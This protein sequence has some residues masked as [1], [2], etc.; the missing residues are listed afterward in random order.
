MKY[1]KLFSPG[2]IGSLEVK[3]RIV[4]PA[5]GVSFATSTGEAGDDIIAY[6]EERAKNGCGLII[7]EITRI[8][9][10]RGVGTSNQLALTDAKHVPQ[11][12]RLVMAVHKHGAKLFPQ[13]HHPGRQTSSR[14]MEGRA[15]VAPSPIPCGICK[16]MPDELTTQQCEEVRNAFIKGAVLA[17]TAGCDGVEVHAAHGYLIDQFLSPHTNQRTDKYGGS[18]TNRMRILVEIITSIKHMCGPNFPVCVRISADEY[19]EGGNTL[20]ETVKIA[21]L[22]ESHGVDAI[23]VSCGT[24]ESSITIIEP[25]S[26][27]QGW[28]RHLAETIRKHI[29]IPVIAVNAIKEPAVAEKLLEEG[30]CDF[31]GVGRGHLADAAWARKA[32]AGDDIAIRKCLGCMYCFSELNTGRKCKCAINPVL[33]REREFATWDRSGNAQPVSVIG[34]GPAGMEAARVLALRGYKVTL[35]EKESALGGQL[36]AADKPPYKEKIGWLIDTMTEELQR[37]GVEV[38]L[39]AEATVDAVKALNPVGVFLAG[40]ARPIIPGIP[41]TDRP[42]V[43]TAEDYLLGKATPSKAVAVIGSGLTGC[44]TAEDLVSKG[45]KVTLVEMLKDIGVGIYPT[46][47]YDVMSRFKK[48]DSAVM[49]AHK[50]MAVT[51]EGAVLLNTVTNQTA[52]LPVDTVVLALGVTPRRALA[53]EFA[54]A[55]DEVIVLGDNTKSGRIAEAIADGFSRAFAL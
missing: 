38:R 45:H 9:N 5:M 24:Y 36:N 33:G 12:E 48:G 37:A 8:D 32:R 22:L 16:E 18:F 52:T 14:L 43:I 20:A 29:K 23:N 7:T 49:T 30:V 41:G 42:N 11:M 54:A 55:F 26:Y 28:K 10:Q 21:R 51:D 25:N 27:P 53:E 15:P 39:G 1:S 50:L 17:K 4:M 34:G 40:G 35:F 44:E 47:L 19:V 3:N 2:K 13:L 31:I 46:V 6:Y